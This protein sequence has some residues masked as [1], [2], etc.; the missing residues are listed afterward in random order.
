[1]DQNNNN[2]FNQNND[3]NQPINQVN[4][5]QNFQ[6]PMGSQPAMNSQINASGSNDK[7]I[8]AK[9]YIIGGL[10]FIVGAVLG[11]FLGKMVYSKN[12]TTDNTNNNSNNNNNN[13]SDNN[14]EYPI[15]I[16][17]DVIGDENGPFLMTL[18]DVFTLTG[19]GTVVTGKVLRGTVRSGDKIQVLGLNREAM[20]VEVDG[21][22]A[23]R[24]NIEV[25]TPGIELGL[26]L[27]NINRDDVLKGQV[28]V[29]SNS[30]KTYKKCDVSVEMYS[31]SDVGEKI[32]INDTDK[33]LFHFWT[34]DISGSIS[35]SNGTKTLSSGQSSNATINLSADTVMEIGI[36]FYVKKGD[37][38]VGKGTVTKLY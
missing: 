5:Q 25:G 3:F 19:R 37:K 30:V 35:F 28:L 15:T 36:K 20:E 29:K 22:E 33:Q 16:T 8:K 9:F 38:V 27:K 6:Q 31:E 1:M 24:K 23:F 18:E 13:V 7:N 17:N 12:N 10:L 26:L 21:I 4:P 34:A 14:G 2:N 11:L 32:T